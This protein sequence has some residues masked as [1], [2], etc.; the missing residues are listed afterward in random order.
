MSKLKRIPDAELEVMKVIWKNEPP[1]TTSILMEQ[2]E[3]EWR[4]QTLISLLLRLVERGFLSTEKNGKERT[5]F[6]LISKEEYLQFESGNFMERLHEN[7]F[8]SLVSSLYD[9]KK[10]NDKDIEEL[11]KWIKE[12][13]N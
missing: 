6:S 3:K 10:L 4:A 7:S 9:G 12:Q 5:F 1:I 13:G 11:S 8:T 2:I